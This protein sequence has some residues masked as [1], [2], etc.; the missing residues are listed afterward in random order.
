M[1]KEHHYLAI[2]EIGLKSNVNKFEQPYSYIDE[3]RN[4]R[5]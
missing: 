3:C 2:F 1:T 5:R 4:K